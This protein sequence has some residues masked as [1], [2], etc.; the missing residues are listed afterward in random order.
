MRLS[1]KADGSVMQRFIGNKRHYILPDSSGRLYAR[2]DAR[3]R[4]EGSQGSQREGREGLADAFL[5]SRLP[6]SY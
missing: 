5:P 1:T 6:L 2:N 3:R 4:D